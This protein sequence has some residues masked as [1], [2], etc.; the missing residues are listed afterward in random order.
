MEKILVVDDELEILKIMRRFIVHLDYEPVV[1]DKWQEAMT[2][3]SR[4]DFALV[5]LDVNMPDKDGFEL[6]GEMKLEK[7]DQK[8]VII[9]GLGPGSAYKY[10][11]TKDVQV[12]DIL[13]K[14]FTFETMKTL[15]K[16]V[17]G[18]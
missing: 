4:H 11:S 9:T 3:F 15:F 1:F 8:I 10:L 12:D 2:E 6:A 5:L 16:K 14:P 7:P 13:Y 17:L 18:S